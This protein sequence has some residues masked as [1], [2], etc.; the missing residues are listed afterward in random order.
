MINSNFVESLY[1]GTIMVIFG[2]ITSYIT[3]FVLGN[4]IIWYPEHS[5]DM[6]SG[7]FFTSIIVYI[8]FSERFI[9]YKC[10]KN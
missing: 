7:T 6:A 10:I 5:I 2:F 8:L 3:D 4:T 9:N 1:F